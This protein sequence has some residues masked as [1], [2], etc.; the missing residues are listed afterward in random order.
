MLKPFPSMN[1]SNPPMTRGQRRTWLALEA[2]QRRRKRAAAVLGIVLSS[3]GH[4]RLAWTCNLPAG[5]TFTICFSVDTIGW[6]DAYDGTDG[7]LY[8]DCSGSPGY[9]RVAQTDGI[10]GVILP[11]SNVVHSDGL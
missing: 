10:G 3:D 6:D 11:Y 9:F 4:G 1:P 2:Q 7:D 5:S 8:R